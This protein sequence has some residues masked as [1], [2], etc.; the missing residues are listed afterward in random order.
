VWRYN[1]PK[2]KKLDYMYVRLPFVPWSI[3]GVLICFVTVSSSQVLL[4][5]II[6]APPSVCVPTVIGALVV[7]IENQK[8]K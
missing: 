2:T 5:F 7:W 6:T 3:A 8:Y 1:K 4:G